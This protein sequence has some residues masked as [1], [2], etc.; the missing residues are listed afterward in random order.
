MAYL[1]SVLT[2]IDAAEDDSDLKEIKEELVSEGYIRAK[3]KTRDKKQGI[4]KSKPLYFVS[5]DGIEI[6]A[7]KSNLQNDELTLKTADSNDIWLHTKNIPGSHV[8]IRCGGNTPP[9]RTVFEAAVIAATYSKAKD[10]SKVPVDYTVRKN[11]K[12]P[13]GAKP[14]MVIYE[15][16]KTIYVDP[17]E[18]FVQSLEKS[19]K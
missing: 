5:S 6:Y 2:A 14:G 18:R 17:N 19:V 15:Q 8:I 13:R 7:G 16:N 12:K 10:S 9:E 3:K 1:E 4:K 11:V